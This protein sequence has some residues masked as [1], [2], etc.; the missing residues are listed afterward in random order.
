M[1]ELWIPEAEDLAALGTSGIMEGGQP[2]VTWH[3]TVCPSGV[4]ADGKHWFDLMH[5]VLRSKEAEP[6]ILWDPVTDR[7]GQYFALNR[8]A[9]A[10]ANDGTRRTNGSGLVNIQIEVVAY[11]DDFTRYWKPG[12]N[13]RALL[14][15]IRSWGVPDF[16]PGGMPCDQ[17]S[18]SWTNYIKA[19]HFGH[20]H[21]PGNDHVDPQ[22]RDGNLLLLKDDDMPLTIEDAKTVLTGSAVLKNPFVANP[23]TAPRVAASY[24]LEETAELAKATSIAVTNARAD[25][26]KVAA[27]V[28]EVKA[29]IAALPKPGDVQPITDEQLERVLR[30]VIGSV[31]NA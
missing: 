27:A 2:K 5:R 28:A 29:Q 21:V 25:I 15:A 23:D 10:L 7:L 9:R 20:V 12:P 17:P 11:A 3:V 31:D 8:S 14:R 30:K 16:W 19:G 4:K 1:A 18:R 13:Y 26:A 22:V 24:V 6:H